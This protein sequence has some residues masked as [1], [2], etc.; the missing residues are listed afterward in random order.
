M[1]WNA[2]FTAFG[3]TATVFAALA[4]PLK[5]WVD[6]LVERRFD[7]LRAQDAAE[8]QEE[9]RRRAALH[10][11][12][13]EQLQEVLE[14]VGK[15]RDTAFNAHEYTEKG[16]SLELNQA[17][18]SIGAMSQ[19]LRELVYKGSVVLPAEAFMVV[20]NLEGPVRTLR[21]MA[22]PDEEVPPDFASYG[23]SYRNAIL[24]AAEQ[25]ESGFQYLTAVARSVRGTEPVG[26]RA[27]LMK[28]GLLAMLPEQDRR[29][30]HD[31][32]ALQRFLSSIRDEPADGSS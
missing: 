16:W 4:V 31:P 25:I 12:Q 15:I 22:M 21:R 29:K 23:E 8:V 27:E 2:F 9:F 32:E 18:R 7:R 26:G 11:E 24:S 5:K 19:P 1:D 17:F 14:L 6:R 28:G 3:G 30:V 13:V 10:D 20:H